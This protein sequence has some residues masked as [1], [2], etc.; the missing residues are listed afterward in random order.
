MRRSLWVIPFVAFL[1]ACGNDSPTTPSVPL[2]DA[3]LADFAGQIPDG[4]TASGYAQLNADLPPA[5]CGGNCVDISHCALL[6]NHYINTGVNEGRPFKQEELSS[7]TDIPPSSSSAKPGGRANRVGFLPFYGKH[8]AQD[9]DYS[10]YTQINHFSATVNPDGSLNTT[11]MET[12][13]PQIFNE[14][15]PAIKAHGVALWYT[16]GGSNRSQ[17]MREV[18][19]DPA[20]RSTFVDNAIAYAEQKGY[21]GID[22]DWEFP[23]TESDASAE[24]AT[25]CE[26]YAKAKPKG[27]GVSVDIPTHFH[28]QVHST[29]VNNADY[30]QCVDMINV[31]AYDY[32][33][34]TCRQNDPVF[35]ATRTMDYWLGRGLPANKLNMG[36]AFYGYDCFSDPRGPIT[37][38]GW[39]GVSLNYYNDFN[40]M[41]RVYIAEDPD[42]IQ[43]ADYIASKQ[44]AGVLYWEITHDVPLSDTG[45]P[46]PNATIVTKRIAAWW[47]DE[48]KARGM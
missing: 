9:V 1:F 30:A 8:F 26:L 31:M 14:L 6:T 5:L 39:S 48:L 32:Y 20:L 27:L 3:C 35:E 43:K 36:I 10:R 29:A 21:Q 19:S 13:N 16:I 7:S 46:A 28:L 38:A 34:N 33:V 12:T 11:Q 45:F 37:W 23:T 41:N 22:I 40:G 2:I 17:N 18:F 44:L 15:L 24:T 4:F 42:R 47:D 25:L